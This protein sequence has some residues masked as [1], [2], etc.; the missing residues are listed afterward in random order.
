MHYIHGQR[1]Q[2]EFSRKMRHCVYFTVHNASLRILYCT[3]WIQLDPRKKDLRM[4]IKILR[5][6]CISESNSWEDLLQVKV[7]GRIIV[8]GILFNSFLYSQSLGVDKIL[9][10]TTLFFSTF[11]PR[12]I[13]F[14]SILFYS[15]LL[16]S[17][18]FY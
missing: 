1:K 6:N 5:W 10:Q 16:Y 11:F 13:L 15:I 9:A 4:E 12:A 2:S 18:L 7:W 3:Q 17:I 14:Y 8:T